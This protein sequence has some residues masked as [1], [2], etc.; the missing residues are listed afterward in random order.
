VQLIS[1]GG[2]V[3]PLMAQIAKFGGGKGGVGGFAP[4]SATL[5]TIKEQKKLPEG[6][7]RTTL[8]ATNRCWPDSATTR[9]RSATGNPDDDPCP[10]S[11]VKVRLVWTRS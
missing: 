8:V 4:V 3:P 5:N 10:Q 6:G 9:R 2:K 1:A 11:R 7:I